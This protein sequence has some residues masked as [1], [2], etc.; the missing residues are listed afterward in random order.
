MDSPSRIE[1]R[2]HWFEL[3]PSQIVDGAPAACGARYNR[4]AQYG[5]KPCKD[6]LIAKV[7][8]QHTQRLITDFELAQAIVE[9][10]RVH[11]PG[12]IQCLN[13]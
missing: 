5:G 8:K 11:C 9:I 12:C 7:K 4:A 10:H 13:G 1:N 6:C 3:H 2:K